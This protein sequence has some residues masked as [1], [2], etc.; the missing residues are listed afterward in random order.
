[1]GGFPVPP[2]AVPIWIGRA[3]I[4]RGESP[5]APAI[6]P[7]QIGKAPIWIGELRSGWERLPSRSA[8]RPSERGRLLSV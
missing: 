6:A 3:P 1:M 8:W 4:Y 7:F 5:I 2:G